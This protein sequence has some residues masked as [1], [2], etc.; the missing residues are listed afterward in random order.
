[1]LNALSWNSIHATLVQV[2]DLGVLLEGASGSG[3]SEIALELI[4]REHRLIADDVV[5]VAVHPS[6]MLVGCAQENIDGWMEIRGV[7][8]LHVPELYGTDA[9]L[10]AAVIDF[11]CRLERWED[12][13][14]HPRISERE[15]VEHFGVMLPMY[16]LPQP[17]IATP[18]VLIELMA[19]HHCGEAQR[20][21]SGTQS[22]LERG[23]KG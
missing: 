1:M 11:V 21:A 7:G 8:L 19:R 23:R 6:E 17:R 9:V 10:P 20:V 4:A 15:M 2:F 13:L 3:K 5:R 16:R 22:F 14:P 12:F 18:A